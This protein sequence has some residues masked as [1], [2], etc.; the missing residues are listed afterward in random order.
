MKFYQAIAPVVFFIMYTAT[1][2]GAQNSTVTNVYKE[3]CVS[4]E[5]GDFIDEFC[6]G[7]KNL[8]D[9]FYEQTGHVKP[10][11]YLL[12][13]ISFHRKDRSSLLNFTFEIATFACLAVPLDKILSYTFPTLPETNALFSASMALEI[14]SK[15]FRTIFTRLADSHLVIKSP[16]RTRVKVRVDKENNQEE[17]VVS[18]RPANNGE[19]C[20]IECR[21][22]LDMRYI[23]TLQ[24]KDERKTYHSRCD[25]DMPKIGQNYTLNDGKINIYLAADYNAHS[26]SGDKLCSLSVQKKLTTGD[27]S[28]DGKIIVAYGEGGLYQ[29]KL[30]PRE[31]LHKIMNPD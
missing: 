26:K 24:L 28:K 10:H 18:D 29:W 5:I 21:S 3:L 14:T 20:G 13:L 23:Q 11:Y 8:N 16:A 15:S 19:L 9:E 17:I 30:S 2:L 12:D 27:V 6:S 25:Y 22:L 1:I 7:E 4:E 31:N